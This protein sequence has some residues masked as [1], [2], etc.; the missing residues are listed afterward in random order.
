MGW[1]LVV[2]HRHNCLILRLKIQGQS[3]HSDQSLVSGKLRLSSYET[4]YKIHRWKDRFVNVQPTIKIPF[5]KRKLPCIFMLKKCLSFYANEVFELKRSLSLFLLHNPL[6]G[7][8]PARH[9]TVQ[10]VGV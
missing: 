6:L 9:Q 8:L 10:S 2:S 3:Q 1:L 5:E 7:E 4:T